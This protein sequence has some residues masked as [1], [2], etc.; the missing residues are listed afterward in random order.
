MLPSFSLHNKVQGVGRRMRGVGLVIKTLRPLTSNSLPL[1]V[2]III[3]FIFFWRIIM[4]VSD[5]SF[6]MLMII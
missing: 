6:M 4:I 1:Y 2:H 5:I 3:F